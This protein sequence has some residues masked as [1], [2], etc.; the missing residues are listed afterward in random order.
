M[1]PQLKGMVW[2]PIPAEIFDFEKDVSETKLF[3]SSQIKNKLIDSIFGKS[4]FQERESFI[5]KMSKRLGGYLRPEE[6]REIIY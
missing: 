1:Y 5:V 4:K 3:I 2:K 6:L